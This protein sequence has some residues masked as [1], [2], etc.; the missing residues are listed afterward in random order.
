MEVSDKGDKGLI[1]TKL[2]F[3]SLLANFA[4]GVRACKSLEIFISVKSTEA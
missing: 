4:A 1:A 3:L 2:T